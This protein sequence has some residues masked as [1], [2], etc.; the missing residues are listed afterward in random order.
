[1]ERFYSKDKEIDLVVH[2]CRHVT[3]VWCLGRVRE[4]A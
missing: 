2:L 3:H 4:G 1:M